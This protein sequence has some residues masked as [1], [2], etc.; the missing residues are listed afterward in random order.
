M[1]RVLL[2]ITFLLSA[3]FLSA[4]T[5]KETWGYVMAD[6]YTEF[7]ADMPIT[8]LCFFGAE[9]NCYGELIEP[10]NFEKL[11]QEYKGRKHL[12]AVCDSTALSHFVID[13][14]YGITNKLITSLVKAA[15]K[16]DGL[17]I[18]FEL[19]PKKDMKNFHMFMKILR[20]KLGKKKM[21][22]VCVP[23]RLK[24]I[25]DDVYD[26][27]K[28]SE[29]VDRVFIMAYDEH[30]STSAPGPIAGM[31]W[32]M[33]I[34]EYAKSKI[35]E[36]KLVFGI[37]FYGRSWQNEGYGKAWYRSGIER[38]KKENKIKEK[39]IN[40]KDGIPYFKFDKKIIVTAYY[41]DTESILLRC[42]K[43]KEKEVN[44][45]GFWRIGQE[46]PEVWQKITVE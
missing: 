14:K 43:I 34:L 8:D 13:S 9:I 30:W 38:I 31:E 29:Y 1:K 16:Y 6:R 17:Q 39:S 32:S 27:A 19:I 3:A 35:P 41:D 44:K 42:K 10:K 33:K 37:P 20:K 11:P 26:Y 18:D 2:C 7:K 12:V 23:A 46:D 22:S 4:V 21:L 40:R 15:E 45:I 28:L 5:F 25:T 36:E 24:D